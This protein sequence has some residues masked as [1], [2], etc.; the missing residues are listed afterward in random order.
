MLANGAGSRAMQ[1]RRPPGAQ[2]ERDPTSN[3]IVGI[4]LSYCLAE[5]HRSRRDDTRQ[6]KSPVEDLLHHCTKPVASSLSS[7]VA[8]HWLA[9]PR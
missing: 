6:A 5:L 9:A 8:C 3:K 2:K 4:M 7:L 1:R